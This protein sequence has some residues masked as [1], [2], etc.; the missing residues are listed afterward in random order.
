MDLGECQMCFN[1]RDADIVAD[2][3][4]EA[5]RKLGKIRKIGTQTI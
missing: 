5:S 2:C 4:P 1:D 3:Q